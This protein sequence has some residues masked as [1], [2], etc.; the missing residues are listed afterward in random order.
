MRNAAVFF[1]LA[2]A[3]IGFFSFL[4]AHHWIDVRAAERRTRERFA[5]L[6]KL[7]D[8]PAEAV[9]RLIELVREDDAREAR[10]EELQRADAR[11]EEL[12]GGTIL[13]AA[14]IGVSIMLGN[15]NATQSLWAVGLIPA[16]IG[17]VVIL[18]AYFNRDRRSEA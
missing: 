14:G 15:L 2:A 13:V 11:R 4:V 10:R 18:F 7:A 6:R 5:L 17:V 8:Q 12:K 9:P 1:F 3:A 16:F